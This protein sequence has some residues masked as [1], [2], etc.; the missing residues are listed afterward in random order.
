MD[1]LLGQISR[2]SF[3]VFVKETEPKLHDALSAALGNDLGSEAT[4]EALAYAW[5]NW[6]KLEAMDNPAGYLYVL[7]RDRGRKMFRRRPVVLL[8]PVDEDRIPWVEPGL[9]PALASLPERQRVV[10]MLVYSFGWTM[11]ETAEF[12]GV[13]KSTVQKY[14]ERG[15]AKVRSSLGV[16]I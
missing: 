13:G 9:V 3:E 6:D 5:E 7:G 4:A 12:L 2:E 1:E 16:K 15:L 14:A 8:L 10:V 11:S